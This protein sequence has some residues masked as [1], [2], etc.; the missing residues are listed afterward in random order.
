MVALG[1]TYNLVHENS[2]WC[3]EL[4]MKQQIIKIVL[5]LQIYYIANVWYK[6]TI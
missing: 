4:H 2:E 1:F 5:I 6:N 3:T